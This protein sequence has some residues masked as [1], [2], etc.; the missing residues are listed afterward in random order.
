MYHPFQWQ[1]ASNCLSVAVSCGCAHSLSLLIKAYTPFL[2]G[3]S[4]AKYP[5]RDRPPRASYLQRRN[6]LK[7]NRRLGP[8]DT[9]LASLDA[10]VAANNPDQDQDGIMMGQVY[11]YGCVEAEVDGGCNLSKQL[12]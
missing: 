5:T 6:P 9:T 1:I 12:L 3:S 7:S 11:T 2:S 10:I 8:S 4:A